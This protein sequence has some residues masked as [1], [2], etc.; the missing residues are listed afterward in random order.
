LIAEASREQMKATT[1]ATSSG[2]MKRF[3][4]EVGRACS[5]NPFSTS[6]T[7][8]PALSDQFAWDHLQSFAARTGREQM[9]R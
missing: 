9:L 1:F 2:S 7:V 3:N 8:F 5:K 4:N 6:A